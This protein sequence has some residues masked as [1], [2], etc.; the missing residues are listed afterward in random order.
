MKGVSMRRAK[1]L[2][3]VFILVL[4]TLFSWQG[5]RCFA[6]SKTKVLRFGKL[7]DGSGKVWSHAVVVVRDDRILSV[8][9]EGDSTT[10]PDAEVID[11]TRY[12]GVPGLIDVHTHM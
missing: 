6:A 3:M 7:V 4:S 5:S 10:P 2:R 8:G 1:G 11:L 9:P 12:T